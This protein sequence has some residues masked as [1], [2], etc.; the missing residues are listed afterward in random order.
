MDLQSF[1]IDPERGFLPL[2]DPL[3]ALP[4]NYSA[5]EEVAADLPKL[6]SAGAIRRAIQRLPA[7][8]ADGL[9][10]DVQRR[11]A[12][13]LLSYLGHAFV[14]GESPPSDS[15]PA[16]VAI[17]WHAV[18]T[19]LGR[20]P[21]LSY[22]SYALDNWRRLEPAG[23]IALGNVVLLQNFLGGMD[24]EWFI[25]VHVEIES[26]AAVAISAIFQAATSMPADDLSQLEDHLSRVTAALD[27]LNATLDRVPERC[28]PYIYYRRVRPYIHG[29]K[30]HPALPNGLTYEGVEKYRGEPQRFRGETGAQSSIVPLLDA[31]LG[32]THQDDALATYLQEMRQYMPPRHRELIAHVERRS[33]VREAVRD[34]GSAALREAYNACVQTLAD[35]RSRYLEYANRYIHEQSEEEPANPSTVG[36]GGTPFMPYLKKHRDET[37]AHLIPE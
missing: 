16:S 20:A 17:P 14:W 33:A 23:P 7:L 24:E 28:D 21:V 30:D 12:M 1:D 8:D 34:S 13:L 32:I 31:G 5:W 29:W 36:T 19:A 2:R 10:G 27:R 25:L 35:F 37:L 9:D 26:K 3:P 4:S 15:L 18:A 22:A 6:L 11:R